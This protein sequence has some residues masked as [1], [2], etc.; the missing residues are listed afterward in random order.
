M[1][2]VV[3]SKWRENKS[4]LFLTP[5]VTEDESVSLENKFKIKIQN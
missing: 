2:M 5:I 1:G 4:G 3:N